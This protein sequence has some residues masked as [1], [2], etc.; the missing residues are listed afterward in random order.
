MSSTA[1]RKGLYYRPAIIVFVGIII[2][3]TIAASIIPD[4]RIVLP[5]II[6]S[7]VL[8]CGSFVFYKHLLLRF[9]SLICLSITVGFTSYSLQQQIEHISQ[10]DTL[11]TLNYSESIVYGKVISNADST[12]YSYRYMLK[13]DSLRVGSLCIRNNENLVCFIHRDTIASDYILPKKYD[14]IK[15]FVELRSIEQTHNPYES[16]LGQYLSRTTGATA[17]ALAHSGYDIY[18]E[19]VTANRSATDIFIDF[20]QDIRRS[21]NA[22]LVSSINDTL[23]QAIV[24][25]VVLGERDKLGSDVSAEFR[26]AGLSHILVVSGFNVAI[27]A[28]LIY[29]LLRCIGMIKLRWRIIISMI[30][31]AL[32]CFTIG[33]EPSVTRALLSVECIFLALLLERKPDVGNITAAIASFAI[34]LDPSQLFNISFQLTYGA[35][36]SLVFIYPRLSQ[37]LKSKQIPK[38]G[39]NWRKYL[40]LAKETF[41]TSMAVL[42]G[43]LPVMIYHF[44]RVTFVSMFSNIIGIPAS[45]LLTILGFLLIPLSYISHPLAMIYGDVTTVLSK[46]LAMTAQLSSNITMLRFALPKFNLLSIILYCIGVLF[47]L[48]SKSIIQMLLRI[49]YAVLAATALLFLHIPLSTR[50]L[51]EDGTLSVLFFDVDQGD[52]ALIRTPNNKTYFIDFGGLRKDSTAIAERTI[53]PLLEAEGITT[54]D[55]GFI[56][57]MH[58]DHYSGLLPL[59]QS[60]FIKQIYSSGEKTHGVLAYRLDSLVQSNHIPV[61]NLQQGNKI[62]LDSDVTMYLFNPDPSL[63]YL[64]TKKPSGTMINHGSLAMKIV[65]KNNSFLFLGDIEASDEERLSRVYGSFL[66]SDVV[67]VAHHGSLFSSTKAMTNASHPR[68]AVISVGAHNGFG[69]PTPNAISRWHTVGSTVLRTDRDGA[70][71]FRSDGKNVRREDWR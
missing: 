58:Q 50:V 60:N 26:N 48:R 35:V 5:S 7:L 69:H 34:L 33:L 44:H 8:F 23:A 55:A 3:I 62:I 56:S 21:I 68:Y 43:L 66:K 71:L 39:N 19:S 47:I 16:N 13:L 14:K 28:A 20:F 65:Y 30:V 12:N 27:V 59:L 42:I 57:H 64:N 18:I 22:R 6:I 53:L 49:C 61:T 54:I 1:E 41:L 63:R 11:S 32:Y 40:S 52:A 51:P 29:Y 37:R 4:K 25:A 36:F 10:L 17:I 9:L 67:K 70:I 2:G 15:A 31:V 45:S 38:P 46:T 24:G